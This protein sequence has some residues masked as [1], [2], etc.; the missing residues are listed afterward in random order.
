M[1]R[2]KDSIR[3]FIEP[4]RVML[5]SMKWRKINSHN[6]TYPGNRF[7][8]NK[9]TVGKETYGQLNVFDYND[10]NA[11]SLKIGNYCSIAKT[12]FFLISGNHEYRTFSTY[13]FQRV[14]FKENY[15]GSKGNIIIEDDVWIGERV[16]V[17]SGVT[18]HKGALVA[19]GAVVVS[20]VPSYAIVGGV[21]AK[22]IKYRFDKKVINELQ[23]IDYS[24]I[25]L[26]FIEQHATELRQIIENE[27]DTH[28]LDAVKKDNVLRIFH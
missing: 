18:I 1:G 15:N 23:K 7:P 20:D 3:E 12:V 28:W 27:N 4:F 24:T 22:V 10:I 5:F 26:Q 9:V 13:P 17:L 14:F 21:P 11:G 25:D 16:T 2:V 19:A 8:I 6:R